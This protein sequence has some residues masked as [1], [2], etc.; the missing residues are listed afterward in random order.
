MGSSY[1]LRRRA[2][3]DI[4]EILNYIA[5]SNPKAAANLY[6]KLSR[7]FDLLAQFPEMGRKRIELFAGIR[8]MPIGS[9]IIFF[10]VKKELEIVRVL[11]GARDINKDLF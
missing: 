10:E 4:S 2:E 5:A 1:K 9:Y 11:H 6:E 3:K 7:L 8:S